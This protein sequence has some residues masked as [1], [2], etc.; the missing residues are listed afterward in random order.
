MA[1]EPEVNLYVA[2][3]VRRH[4]HD[5]EGLEQLVRA[6]H[7]AFPTVVQAIA[8]KMA[9]DDPGSID[10]AA[11]AR[12]LT[13]AGRLDAADS[14]LP[15]PH[16]LDLEWRFSSSCCAA[17]A[18]LVDEVRQPGEPVALLGTPGFAERFHEFAKQGSATLFEGRLEACNALRSIPSLDIVPGD[19]QETWPQHSQGFMAAVADPPWYPSI[20]EIFL[21]A[22]AGLL[23]TGG[24]LYFCAP[25]LGT[26]PNLPR[27][28][29]NLTKVALDNGLVLESLSPSV[30]EYESPPFE[31]AALAAAGLHAYD[32]RWRRGDLLRFRRLSTNHDS[33]L[34]TTDKRH[35]AARAE[36]WR[37]V[38]I[39]RGRI[40]V[41]VAS[42]YPGAALL[43]SIVPGDVLDS[44]STRDPRRVGVNVWTAT[45]RVFRTGIPEAL[46]TSL[47]AV[48]TGASH[49]GDD[50]VV[51]AAHRLIAD[52]TCTLRSLGID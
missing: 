7:G 35:H 22:G 48:M 17:L 21:Q 46:L 4:G 16:P 38:S 37:E 33:A 6:C 18:R 39:G 52:E 43:E 50:E 20:T 31:I 26:R 12:T 9:Q 8:R 14:V 5:A 45:N 51:N 47:E 2:S 25:G 42:R 23:R 36:D 3:L 40:R 28:R 41:D 15:I 1:S 30:I 49:D 13:D 32:S 34:T 19:V 24:V 10:P 27:E 44:V 11:L 29:A